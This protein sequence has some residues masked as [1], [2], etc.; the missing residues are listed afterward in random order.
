MSVSSTF[1]HLECLNGIRTLLKPA[2]AN[3]RQ[4]RWQTRSTLGRFRSPSQKRNDPLHFGATVHS[5]GPL[6]MLSMFSKARICSLSKHP[7]ASAFTGNAL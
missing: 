7:Q 3:N 6:N 1:N 4:L 2:P 5:H